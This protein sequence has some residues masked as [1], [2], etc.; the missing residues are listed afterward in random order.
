MVDPLHDELQRHAGGLRVL[1]RDLLRDPHAADD[2][3]QAACAQALARPPRTPGPLGGWL[4]RTVVNFARQWHRGERR[5][6][7]R[8]AA[9]PERD[10]TPG[11]DE[12]L[13]RR[14]TLR[15]VTTAVLQLEEPYQT[16]IF[17]RYFEDLPPRA[18][19]R[20][21][22]AGI[23]T[24]KSRLARGLAQLRTRLDALRDGNGE[25]RWR[26]ALAATFG[27]PLAAPLLPLPTGTLLVSSTTKTLFA[28]GALCA[29]GLL[30]WQLQHDPAPRPDTAPEGPRG[31]T[32]AAAAVA[33]TPADDAPT[34]TD[35][36]PR[37]APPP[38]PWLDH[39]YEVALD[40]LVVDPLGLP[41]EGHTLRLG[42]ASCAQNLAE[43]ATGADGRITLAW[44][45]RTQALEVQLVD[46]RGQ[47]RRVTLQHGQR[48]QLTLLGR[49]KEGSWRSLKTTERIAFRARLDTKRSELFV[50]TVGGTRE[51]TMR[52]GLHPFAVFGDALAHV[53]DA[54]TGGGVANALLVES[55]RTEAKAQAGFELVMSQRG[56]AVSFELDKP[57]TGTAIDG[58]V[59]GAD[60]KP[61]AK[62]PVQLFGSGP[63][64]LQFAQ[65]DD[66]GR[67][68]FA[69]VVPGE[70]R[71]RAGGDHRGLA[72]TPVLVA[73]APATCTVNLQRG[74]CVRGRA[75]DG[76]GKPRADHVVEWRALDGSWA[77]VTKTE[78]DGTFVLANLPPG[79][80]AVFLFDA[81]GNTAIPIATAPSVLPDTGD[82]VLA[83]TGAGSALRVDALANVAAQHSL[84]VWHA[85][86][87]L[88]CGLRAPEKGTRW[89][90]PPLPAGFY[91]VE[92]RVEGAG[93][94]ALGRHWLDGE[95]DFDLGRVEPTAGGSV[96]IVIPAAALPEPQQ[97]ALEIY[98]LRS[99]L[100]VRAEL[101][102][103]P[104]ERPIQLPVGDYALAW[105]H[106]DGG[107]RFEPFTVRRD[108]ETVVQPQR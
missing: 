79:P 89:T 103:V 1:A 39:P 87:G 99:D 71:V 62:V 57:A 83:A 37:P 86:T 49:A 42:P 9:L 77:D 68:R 46:P 11:V 101:A 35:A 36:A 75:V 28:A 88:A 7:A 97:Q 96:R 10:A 106:A 45:T 6:A 29:G 55:K 64:P 51:P 38:A 32:A 8:E 98:A 94:T 81:G 95:H 13:A 40:V 14:D 74:A 90:S 54:V 63:Q 33:S 76:A 56:T 3:A 17:L 108:A 18:I 60:G 82:L 15:A 31:P 4:H 65:S 30:A 70:L 21:T 23:A 69:N 80:A 47:T 24:V 67:F 52:A 12:Q 26:H 92:L 41:V 27:L 91:D 85:D 104:L 107:V 5:R 22:G 43:R 100:D 105:R 34:R 53:P 66:Q 73:D 2:V 61:A 16:A 84:R 102:P 93:T 58:V 25:R 19:A 20:R 44:R 59:F 48:T 72:T 78:P 50:E